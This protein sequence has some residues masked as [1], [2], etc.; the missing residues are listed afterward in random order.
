MNDGLDL[1]AS[2][3]TLLVIASG[4]L[5]CAGNPSP[6][7][8]WTDDMRD[9]IGWTGTLTVDRSTAASG[10]HTM[11][12]ACDFD[13]DPELFTFRMEAAETVGD[14]PATFSLVTGTG[15]IRR[16]IPL[17]DG[18]YPGVFQYTEIA[19]NGTETT[20]TGNA[21]LTVHIASDSLEMWR[22]L[23][24]RASGQGDG[25]HIGLDARCW[26]DPNMLEREV[27]VS[28]GSNM[29]SGIGEM[30]D[31]T[32]VMLKKEHPDG[33]QTMGS[34]VF[35]WQTAAVEKP[36]QGSMTY[37]WDG[38]DRSDWFEYEYRDLWFFRD[39]QR[40][41]TGWQPTDKPVHYLSRLWSPRDLYFH[42]DSEGLQQQ[43]VRAVSLVVNYPFF[44][45]DREHHAEQVFA[46]GEP[47]VEIEATLPNG[48]YEI[49]YT[50]TWR[51]ED[52]RELTESGTSE[53][54]FWYFASP[55]E[56]A[57]GN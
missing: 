48:E 29:H 56:V 54:A 7:I 32:Q 19:D 26:A 38:W 31:S 51:F 16:A 8:D 9:A 6:T 20:F 10:T 3:L 47:N 18:E 27:L 24:V 37:P 28:L 25:V 44:D 22:A 11:S 15:P 53:R 42:F 21:E 23:E 41:D 46:K 43:G 34:I 17:Q 40:F 35:N 14:G 30:V 50:L 57:S 12:T 33:T 4:L 45:G 5:G 2:S 36:V 39:G 1:R 52:G 49:G 13:P 55:G